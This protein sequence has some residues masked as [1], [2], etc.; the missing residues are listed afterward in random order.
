MIRLWKNFL[1]STLFWIDI[2]AIGVHAAIAAGLLYSSIYLYHYSLSYFTAL[3]FPMEQW[4]EYIVVLNWL[5]GLA[6]IERLKMVGIS[7]AAICASGF[8]LTMGVL[9]ANES[10][11]KLRIRLG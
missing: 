11:V 8:C 3:A 4:K 5:Y 9:A 10:L 6:D 7:W 1:G 2:L